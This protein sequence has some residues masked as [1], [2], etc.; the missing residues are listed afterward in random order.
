MIGGTIWSRK[1]TNREE[2]KQLEEAYVSQDT[3][4]TEPG[5]PMLQG[6][7]LDKTVI[8]F[9]KKIFAKGQT[10]VALNRVKTLEG[11]DA[12]KLLNRPH[13][14]K[15]LTKMLGV[16]NPE[17]AEVVLNTCLEKDYIYRFGY[18]WVG[19]GLITA[20][21]NA[22]TPLIRFTVPT[23]RRH[24]KLLAPAFNQ[25]VLNGF[26]GVFNR[27]SSVMVEA[28]AKELGR[29]RFDANVY[30]GAATLEMICQTAM[31]TPMDQQNIVSPPYLEATHKIFELVTKRATSFWLHP[32]F[33]YNLL[34]YKKIQ[35][36]TL[37]ILHHVSNT[38]PNVEDESASR[39]DDVSMSRHLELDGL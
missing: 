31:G 3:L 1:A 21:V 2:W 25:N 39:I 7:T 16:T 29:E 38:D 12:N 4:I 9:G 10:Y 33:M 36:D 22:L 27:Q 5:N 18:P 28:M 35:D 15:D 34:G 32:Q 13:Y 37:R 24:H 17:D 23:W 8:D 6:T 11:I 20:D 19:K 30:I 26:M 14:E